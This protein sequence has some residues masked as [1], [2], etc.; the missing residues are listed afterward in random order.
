[1]PPMISSKF[2][3]CVQFRMCLICILF[4]F[5]FEKQILFCVHTLGFLLCIDSVFG[6]QP[7][8]IN[9][10]M[11]LLPNGKNRINFVEIPLRL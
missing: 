4:N 1:M 5:F 10:P 2:Q 11:V 7:H 9:I 3:P 8:S 6:M